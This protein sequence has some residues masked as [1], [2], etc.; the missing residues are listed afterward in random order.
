MAIGL[1]LAA[2]AAP[3]S[4]YENSRFGYTL[5]IPEGLGV[6]A[7]AEDGSGATWQT[8]TFQVQVYGTNNP[9]RISAER[10]FA[11]VRKAAGDRIVDERRSNALDEYAW[12]EILYLKEGRRFHRKT[13]VGEGSVNTVEV[14]YA[15]KHRE[16]KQSIGE[17]VVNSLRPGELSQTH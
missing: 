3:W 9:Y 13:F 4:A 15:Y 14:S 16:A 6:V 2:A 10:W 11:N 1:V 5:M 7:R 8:G 12:H 17:K